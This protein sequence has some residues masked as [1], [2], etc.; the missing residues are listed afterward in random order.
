MSKDITIDFFNIKTG[1]KVNLTRD[2]Q[3][4]AF[5]ESSDLG[6]NPS[7]DKG[8]RLSP[9]WVKKLNEAR[10]DADFIN[11]VSKAVKDTV[12][13]RH[14]AVELFKRERNLQKQAQ[15]ANDNKYE[16]QYQES[17]INPKKSNS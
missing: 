17:I 11:A 5:I 6:V 15:A 2:A 8:W 14:L 12:T 1:E 10:K 3:I 16:K 4:K 7:S 13:D 9:E